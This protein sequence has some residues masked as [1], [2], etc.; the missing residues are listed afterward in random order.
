MP[1]DPNDP[2]TWGRA[3]R[4]ESGTLRRLKGWGKDPAMASVYAVRGG[5][6][7]SAAASRVLSI[8][9][10]RL[11]R[12]VETGRV[13]GGPGYRPGASLGSLWADFNKATGRRT[14][15]GLSTP[16]PVDTRNSF[17]VANL[18]REAQRAEDAFRAEVTDRVEKHERE[19]AS[20]GS[21]ALDDAE[22]VVREKE[23]LDSVRTG[24]AGAGGMLAQDGG[25]D[26][27]HIALQND[28][29]AIG[30][31]RKTDASRCYFCALMAAGGAVYKP[32]RTAAF[33]TNPHCRCQAVPTFSRHY[34]LSSE[35]GKFA[36]MWRDF[37]GG[38]LADWRSY[39]S[40]GRPSVG[41][42]PSP[43]RR[44]AGRCPPA[45]GTARRRTSRSRARRRWRRS[46][47]RTRW[48]RPRRPASRPNT[49]SATARARRGRQRR[50]VGASTAGGCGGVRVPSKAS[51][52]AARTAVRGAKWGRPAGSTVGYRAEVDVTCR[53]CR[54]VLNRRQPLLTPAARPL[55]PDAE[56]L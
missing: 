6:R 7:E 40:G 8:A 35:N 10:Y 28:P 54:P 29:G 47:A 22:L 45:S 51:P 5:V 27:I 23:F 53:W 2:E 11:V 13:I 9:F 19:R 15:S 25:R 1:E 14:G 21:A 56:L 33:G 31:Y 39:Y 37:G 42:R 49:D 4:H 17:P 3:F 36:R 43:P 12:A 34:Q 16:L 20:R 18:K 38:S 52:G 32:K 24:S 44:P 55:K 26:M 50:R 48:R 41:W 30:Y 46:R